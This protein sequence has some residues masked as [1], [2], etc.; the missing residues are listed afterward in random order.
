MYYV[1]MVI[2]FGINNNNQTVV[3]KQAVWRNHKLF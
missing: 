3:Q 2:R 1:N